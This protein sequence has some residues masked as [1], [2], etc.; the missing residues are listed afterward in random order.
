MLN[1]HSHYALIE[2]YLQQ[3]GELAWVMATIV[4]K[5]GSSYRSPGAMMLVN[6]LGQSQGLVSGGCLEANI[7][8]QAKKVFDTEQARY[9]EY[10]MR[11]EEGYAAELGVGCKGKIGILLQYLTPGHTRL[12]TRLFQRLQQGQT[13]YLQHR[14]V[15]TELDSLNTLHL[16]ADSGEW[17]MSSSLD[18]DS[19][20]HILPEKFVNSQNKHQTYQLAQSALSY[21]KIS[22]PINLWLFGGG[23][24][25]LPLVSMAAQLGWQVTVVDHRSSYAR[26]S[27][28]KHAK[29]IVSVHPDDFCDFAALEKADAAILMSHNL[30]L[31]A[32]WLS[33]LHQQS[34]AQY[35]GLLGP[36]E[37]RHNV[38][39]Q[40]NIRDQAWLSQHVNGPAGLDIGGELPESIA[41]S[42]LAQCH[43]VLHHRTGQSLSGRFINKPN[44]DSETFTE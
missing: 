28:F 39:A 36:L 27:H 16:Y 24:D 14:F 11:E 30:Q 25:A 20:Q 43:S 23:S 41:L 8:L 32:A 10:D 13:S 12:L 5:V 40:S 21:S 29:H 2:H 26:A 17:L 22:A 7:V 19:A 3:Q 4:N 35:I 42:I 6:S 15:S 18:Q 1:N 34:K 33:I 37:R 44:T 38:E 9:I 31:D